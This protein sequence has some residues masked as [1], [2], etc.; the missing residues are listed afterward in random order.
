MEASS[1]NPVSATTPRASSSRRRNA[2]WV[3]EPGADVWPPAGAEEVDLEGFYPR[4]ADEGGLAYGPLFRGLRGVWR[5][6]GE[7]FVEAALPEDAEGAAD[8]GAFGVH[9]A[10]LDAVLHG[11]EFVE[12]AGQGLPFEWSGVSLHAS[13]ASV[14]RARL[15]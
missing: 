12:G 4:L 14:L 13:G 9:P 5:S 7:V 2:A 1:F 6:G 11:T 3:G 10:L 15:A 8:A